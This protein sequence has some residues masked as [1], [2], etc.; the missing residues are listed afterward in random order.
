[1]DIKVSKDKCIGV[2]W[3]NLI[4]VR[5]NSIKN[6]TKKKI[7][8]DRGKRSKTANDFKNKNKNQRH[9]KKQKQSKTKI[10]IPRVSQR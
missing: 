5:W 6:L 3:E 10:R 7:V 4:Y 9:S 2:D 8:V 1:M